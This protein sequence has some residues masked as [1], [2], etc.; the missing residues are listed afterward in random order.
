MFVDP[1]AIRALQNML[2]EI[3]ALISTATPLP[4]NRTAHCIDLL[5]AA[6]ALTDDMI[7]RA[8][9]VQ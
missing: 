9:R 1:V 3:Q 8:S 5:E 6:R 4:D 7:R 2:G